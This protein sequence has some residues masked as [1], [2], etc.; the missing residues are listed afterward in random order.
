MGIETLALDAE[1]EYGV[2]AD[3][4]GG[5]NVQISPS[6]N[7]IIN[8][9]DVEP[10]IT[11]DEI[12]GR[13]SATLNVENKIEDV[14]Q[15]LLTMARGSTRTAD[16][17]EVTKQIIAEAASEEYA[18]LGITNDVNSLYTNNKTASG[19]VNANLG[20]KKKPMPT[21]GSWYRRILLNANQNQNPD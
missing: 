5:L 10:E 4:L 12:T 21:I 1:G 18:S 2:V 14:T 3:A 6:S 20:R 7:T 13:E 15:V 8:P 9:F 17:N 19:A 11:K 16:V